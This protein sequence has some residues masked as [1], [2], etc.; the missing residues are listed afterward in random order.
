MDGND[1]ILGNM[2]WILLTFALI[3]P[4][5]A[6]IRFAFNRR[7]AAL[8]HIAAFKSNAFLIYT[9]HAHWGENRTTS[10]ARD[11]ATSR[12][13]TDANNDHDGGNTHHPSS[14]TTSTTTAPRRQHHHLHHSDKTLTQLILIGDELC[15]FLTLP[16]SSLSRHRILRAG[17]REAS[18]TMEASYL[19]FDSLLATRVSRL[20][21]LVED[22]RVSRGMAATE[23][24]RIRQWERYLCLAMEELR[25]LKL[26]RT[27]QA[28]RAFADIFGIILP[29]FYAPSFAQLA[30]NV[31][32][33]TVGI[34]FGVLASVCLLALSET[35]NVLE[36]PFVA[37]LTLDGIDVHEEL[38]VLHWRQLLNARTAAFPHSKPFQLPRDEEFRV[39]GE[40]E[41]AALMTMG[42]MGGGGIGSG[43]CGGGVVVD[44]E[45]AANDKDSVVDSA[46]LDVMSQSGGMTS[47][48]SAYHQDL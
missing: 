3:L 5:S 48:I 30:H 13:E 8:N 43:D 7:E 32:S 11:D 42:R 29:P 19:L 17:R 6:S 21:V 34:A 4:I 28:L 41:N 36:D 27:P 16:T 31:Q 45:I 26:Y 15:R 37:N 39:L 44:L 20:T 14:E 1:T 46:M 22:L 35:V 23:A 40:E 24:S 12:K 9:A 33:L 47:R 18:V 2:E 25:M 10:S 38:S